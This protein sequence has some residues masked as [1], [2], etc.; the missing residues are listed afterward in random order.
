MRPR[1]GRKTSAVQQHA[2]IHRNGGVP[3]YPHAVADGVS[4]WGDTRLLMTCDYQAVRRL[5]DLSG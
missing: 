1:E 2:V 3:I 5:R 4:A